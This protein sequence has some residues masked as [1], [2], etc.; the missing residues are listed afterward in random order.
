MVDADVALTDILAGAARMAVPRALGG[1]GRT[2]REL[3][4]AIAVQSHLCLELGIRAASQR[5]LVEVLLRTENAGLREYRLPSLLEAHISGNCAALWPPT[6]D[7]TPAIA[8][9]TGRGWVISGETAAVP[10]LGS[11]WFLAS[12]PVHFEGEKTYSLVLLRS[13]EDGIDRREA[14][15]PGL[16]DIQR[17]SL[18]LRRVFFREDEM[19]ASDG[20]AFVRELSPLA[21]AFKSAV[22]AGACLAVVDRWTD[23][24]GKATVVHSVERMLDTSAGPDASIALVGLRREVCALVSRPVHPSIPVP[25]ARRAVLAQLRHL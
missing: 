15:L 17:A 20:P 24:A 3:V 7:I 2:L 12:A 10:N 6:E 22:L 4:S 25:A 13:D 18:G 9:D 11:D 21:S 8:R 5:L 19:V 1:D 23:S 16:Q 14:P